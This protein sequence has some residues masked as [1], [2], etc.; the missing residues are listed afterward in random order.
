MSTAEHLR[1]RVRAVVADAGG[2]LYEVS[3]LDEGLRRA[4]ERL[5]EAAGAEWT[6]SGL[7]G[8]AETS[9][10]A[11]EQAWLVVGA[12]A[13]AVEARALQRVE[14]FDL[15]TGVP[16]AL[17]NWAVRQREEFFAGLEGV[18]RRWLGRAVP[19]GPWEE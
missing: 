17:L 5:N 18:R 8:A 12:A 7:D 9:L 1:D 2:S 6:V 11:A 4:L 14:R 3:L 15:N 10:P 13:Y 16:A 19:Y